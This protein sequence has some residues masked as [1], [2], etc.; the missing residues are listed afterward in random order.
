MQHVI[1]N[2]YKWS[3]LEQNRIIKESYQLSKCNKFKIFK[4]LVTINHHTASK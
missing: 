1:L 4:M 3:N 2:L